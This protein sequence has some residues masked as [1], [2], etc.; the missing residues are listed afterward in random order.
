MVSTFLKK[1]ELKKYVGI[2]DKIDQ[3]ME[4]ANS[5]LIL[6]STSAVGI[7]ALS[8]AHAYYAKQKK[9]EF[10]YFRPVRFTYDPFT[11]QAS[12]SWYFL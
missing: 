8:M 4:K 1:Y 7:W 6:F 11:K 12:I 5:N 2:L 3:E 9:D 10:A